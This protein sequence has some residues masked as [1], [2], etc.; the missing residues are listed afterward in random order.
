MR[1][2]NS[3]LL[4][5]LTALLVACDQTASV[6]LDGRVLLVGGGTAAL[7]DPSTD[8]LARAAPPVALRRGSTATVLGDGRVLIAGGADDDGVLASAELFDPQAGGFTPT[9]DLGVPRVFHT[10][11]RLADGRVLVTG[12]MRAAPGSTAEDPQSVLASAELYDPA[13]GRWTMTGDLVHGRIGH[14]ATSLPDGRVVI[15]GGGDPGG[16]YATAE[17]YDPATGR[18]NDSGALVTARGFHTATLLH[19][20]QVLVVGG[21][22]GEAEGSQMLD[23]AERFDPATGTFEPAGVLNATRLGNTATLLLDGRV[24]IAGGLLATE[25]G[26][27]EALDSAELYDPTSG[28]STP[29]GSMTQGRAGHTASLLEDGR[30]L[31]A[32]PGSAPGQEP[33]RYDI[34]LSSWEI[35]D[36]SSGTFDRPRG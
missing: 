13:T 36:P 31:L 23:R 29:T 9:G 16:V 22:T 17:S 18:F 27:F 26:T 24:L 12:G 6:L 33:G 34:A 32:G 4:V 35:Y 10:A 14:S 7:F 21:Q 25:S 1:P 11:T 8:T 30:V 19:D 15:I 3:L 20:G 5:L 2:A 28:T